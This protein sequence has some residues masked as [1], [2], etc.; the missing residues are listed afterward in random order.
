[1]INVTSNL[2]NVISTALERLNGVNIN[3]MTREQASTLI[4]VVRDRVHINGLDSKNAQIGVYTKAYIKLRSGQYSNA[5][6]ITRGK[7]SGKNKNAGTYTKGKSIGAARPR[8]NRGT[9]S[10]VILSLT[11]QMENDMVIM[12]IDNG[13]GIGYSNPVNYQKAKW[14]ENTYHKKIWDLTTEERAEAIKIAERYIE[15]AMK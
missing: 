12:P 11:R 1:M 13:W 6:I 14:A 3:M 5:S 15:E 7:N 4:G 9:D 8:Y 10:K 2:G